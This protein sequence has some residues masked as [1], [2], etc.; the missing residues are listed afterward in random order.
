MSSD[1]KYSV[2]ML[3]IADIFADPTFNCRGEI[4]THEIV[5]LAADIKK[6]GLDMPVTVRPYHLA[7]HKYKWHL[8]AG[9][10]RMKACEFAG[11]TEI[12]TFVRM[13][14]D[15]TEARRFN[16]RENMHRQN[17]NPVQEARALKYFL[18]CKGTLGNNLFTDGEL[19]EVFGQSRGWVQNRRQ[20]LMLP[21]EIQ[22]VAAS[23]ILTV[24]HVQKLVKMQKAD[25]Y[26]FVRKIKEA[27]LKNQTLDLTPSVARASDALKVRKRNQSEI[28]EMGGLIYDILGPNIATR[29]AAWS[30]AVISTAQL[31]ESI[32]EYAKENAIEYKEPEFLRK[33]TAGAA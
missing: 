23:G 13:N 22:E 28:T 27:A 7:D 31:M 6:R 25:Q 20:L 17:L 21:D 4:A 5:D 3:P 2:T 24:A 9:H 11:W 19:A 1:P 26:E 29:F 8:I 33:A 16:L 32:R 10:R 15:E 18:D 12:P 14:V 30:N